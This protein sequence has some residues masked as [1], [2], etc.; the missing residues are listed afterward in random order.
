M[1]DAGIGLKS[2]VRACESFKFNGGAAQD[3]ALALAD[4][5]RH[6]AWV[7][8]HATKFLKLWGLIFP[9]EETLAEAGTR[10]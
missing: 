9:D 5:V 4:A 3:V 7:E 10:S 2:E 8:T 6:R 1:T